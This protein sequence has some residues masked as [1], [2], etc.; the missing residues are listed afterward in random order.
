[1]DP[2]SRNRVL[3]IGGAL[4]VIALLLVCGP[5]QDRIGRDR[6]G[7]PLPPV[8]AGPPEPS[9]SVVEPAPKAPELEPQP[10]AAPTPEP[11]AAGAAKESVEA[12][13]VAAAPVGSSA[14]ADGAAAAE[15]ATATATATATAAGAA[16][17]ASAGGT[18]TA[19]SAPS[20]AEAP[21]V[22]AAPP[23]R[24]TP[25]TAFDEALAATSLGSTGDAV[26]VGPAGAASS[27]FAPPVASGGPMALGLQAA[28][29]FGVDTS[30][31]RP[32]DTPGSGCQNLVST[33]AP[34]NPP[35]RPGVRPV[36]PPNPPVRPGTRPTP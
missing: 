20:P 24:P 26:G 34:P 16:A 22:S 25:A 21:A 2:T 30:L 5:L 9:E 18:E 27:R 19:A 33:A 14:P 7:T 10:E 6:P 8:A 29:Q 13:P 32:C 23:A 12:T 35:I 36:P 28:Q 3:M 1:M 11:I 15:S 31:R 17:G 4:I